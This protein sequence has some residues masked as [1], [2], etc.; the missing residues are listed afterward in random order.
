MVRKN[1]VVLGAG[2]GGVRVT[3]RLSSFLLHRSD[4]QI[5]LIDKNE[6]HT[7]MTQLHEVA[8][9]VNDYNDVIVPLQDI[10]DERNI[11][12]I[13]G[14]VHKINSANR[15]IELEKGEIKIPFCYLVIALGGEPEYFGIDGL[16]EYS[17]SLSSLENAKELYSVVRKELSYREKTLTFVVGGGGLT[18]VEMAGELACFIGR[19]AEENH[20]K[21]DNFKIILIESADE[22]LP[23][24][25]QKVASYA[26][27]SLQ[28]SGVE[29]ITADRLTRVTPGEIYL[30][31]GRTINFTTF[32]WAGGIRGN[33]IIA[34]SGFET[35]NRGRMIVNSCLQYVKDK[36]VFAVG[37]S[38]LAKDPKTGLPVL[39]TAQAALRQG[40]VVAENILA[41]ITGGQRVEY[42]PG[43]I[44]LLINVGRKQGLGEAKRFFKITGKPAA[45][46]KKLIPMRYLY[47][48][49]GVKLL[50][51]R[52]FSLNRPK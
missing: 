9:G 15:E 35:D 5:V 29:V 1:I 52:L 21:E 17:T 11:T 18:G 49:G 23:G 38:A 6:Y 4:Y 14:Q 19:Y 13:K 45:W 47:L 44:L 42:Q 39:P 25:S 3:Q 51:H 40:K 36:Q 43:N 28:Q 10:L 31:S 16:E 46:L 34:E 50:G 33:R 41:E 30:A 48:L 7:F 26:R 27:Q 8:L 12:F 20:I 37:D 22:L 24:M 32:I 2:Y